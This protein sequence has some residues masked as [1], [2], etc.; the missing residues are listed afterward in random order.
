MATQI[1]RR[2]IPFTPFE[3]SIDKATVA[4]VSSTGVH[5]KSQEPFDLKDEQGDG[6]FRVIPGDAALSDLM[7]TNPHYDHTDIDHDLDCVFPLET[8]RA[9]V[10]EGRIGG[11]AEKSIGLMGHTQ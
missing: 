10:A 9:L 4:I 11:V 8:L 5:M 2:C 1:S 3:Q 6:S 7:I